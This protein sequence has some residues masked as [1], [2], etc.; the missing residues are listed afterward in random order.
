MYNQFSY[1]APW[2]TPDSKD[3]K[4]DPAKEVSGTQN[5]GSK[6]PDTATNMFNYL[7]LGVG[8]LTVGFAI[9]LIYS[10]EE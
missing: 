5:N 9:L 8:L 4:N 2:T 3:D 1:R 6:L 7:A 10:I